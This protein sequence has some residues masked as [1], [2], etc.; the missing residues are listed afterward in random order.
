MQLKWTQ[1]RNGEPLIT[2][3]E[4]IVDLDPTSGWYHIAQALLGWPYG[5]KMT[6]ENPSGQTFQYEIV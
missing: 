3:R 1:L 2:D 4:D 5:S 6:I